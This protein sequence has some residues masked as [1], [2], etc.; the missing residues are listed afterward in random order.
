MAVHVNL[1]SAV[2]YLNSLPIAKLDG[3]AAQLRDKV[4]ELGIT[5]NKRARISPEMVPG[6]E[7]TGGTPTDDI[8]F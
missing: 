1:E 2:R 5:V 3:I 6:G 8:P 4:A 7:P